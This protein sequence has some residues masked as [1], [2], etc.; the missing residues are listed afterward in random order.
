MTPPVQTA[1]ALVLVALA[2]AWLAW[3]VIKKRRALRDAEACG[4]DCGCPTD[5]FKRRLRK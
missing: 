5:D 1:L 2:V 4:S 3:R